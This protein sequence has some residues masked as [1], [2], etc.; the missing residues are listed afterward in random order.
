MTGHVWGEAG[1][2][3]MALVS[4]PAIQAGQTGEKSV[5]RDFSIRCLLPWKPFP[6]HPSWPGMLTLMG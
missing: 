4:P 2:D 6:L 5:L 1:G 3:F